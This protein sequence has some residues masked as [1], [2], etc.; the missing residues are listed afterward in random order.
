MITH[1]IVAC[2]HGVCGDFIKGRIIQNQRMQNQRIQNPRQ[3]PFTLFTIKT[4]L[5]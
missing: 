4:A 5:G 1:R 2:F 3:C